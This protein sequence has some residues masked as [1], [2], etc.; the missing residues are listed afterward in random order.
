MRLTPGSWATPLGPCTAFNGVELFAPRG[1]PRKAPFWAASGARLRDAACAASK[2]L[3]PHRPPT[4]HRA[5]A[6]SPRR[7][8]PRNMLAAVLAAALVAF[9][10]AAVSPELTAKARLGKWG[11]A[12][13]PPEPPSPP[14]PAR[15]HCSKGAAAPRP[16][17]RPIAH[18]P[19]LRPPICTRPRPQVFPVPNAKGLAT[20]GASL[21]KPGAC[22]TAFDCGVRARSGRERM[23]VGEN[24]GRPRLHPAAELGVRTPNSAQ[25]PTPFGRRPRGHYLEAR[26][27]H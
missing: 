17:R 7:M 20:L 1:R 4:P 2:M 13:S 23:C 6:H 14:L 9:A 5:P 22:L 12:T 11:P 16:P 18:P 3:S 21:A 27:R 19:T 10:A 26:S 15:A 24:Q 25:L 8:A